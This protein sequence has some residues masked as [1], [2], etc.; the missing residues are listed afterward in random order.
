MKIKKHKD[1]AAGIVQ[2]EQK[3]FELILGYVTAKHHPT[4]RPGRQHG[5]LRTRVGYLHITT[6]TYVRDY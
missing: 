3:G 6:H 1:L 4:L 2:K 5:R